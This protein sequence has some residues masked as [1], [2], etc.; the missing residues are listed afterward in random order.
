MCSKTLIYPEVFR[1]VNKDLFIKIFFTDIFM[2][3]KNCKLLK[4]LIDLL[5]K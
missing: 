4:Y 1:D 3:V 5:D 2:T